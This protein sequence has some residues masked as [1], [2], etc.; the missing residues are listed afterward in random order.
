MSTK[1]NLAYIVVALYVFIVSC[2]PQPS[3]VTPSPAPTQYRTS[4]PSSTEEIQLVEVETVPPVTD[5]HITVRTVSSDP[6]ITSF[7]WLSDGK[8]YYTIGWDPRFN[9]Y[10][11]MEDVDDSVWFSFTLSTLTSE[12][13]ENPYTKIKKDLLP[14]LVTNVSDQIFDLTISP[15]GEKVIYTRP[16]SGYEQPEDIWPHYTA[17]AEIWILDRESG[18]NYPLLA[19]EEHWY[20]CGAN[21]SIDSKWFND[22]T[23]VIGSC[24]FD[25]GI[26]RV[27]FLIDLVKKDV[28]FLDFTVAEEYIPSEEIAV[29][30]SSP[31]LA[32]SY[33]TLWFTQYDPKQGFIPLDLNDSNILVDDYPALYP[34]WSANDQFVYYWTLGDTIRD[35]ENELSKYQLW[36]LEKINVASGETEVVLSES[37]LRILM[38]DAMYESASGIRWQ[39]SPDEKSILLYRVETISSPA[40]LLF[41]SGY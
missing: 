17:P 10:K 4:I 13:L 2:Q 33:G 35:P 20:A 3:R 37:D 12:K 25:Y 40:A 30:H 8:I 27:Y 1:K 32:F 7:G 24:Y 41:I 6:E 5:S 9:S 34:A 31:Q 29:A 15:S 22:E 38:G 26:I 39:L 14:I 36:W 11:Q 21:L 16:P 28:Q 23:L 18:E 19:E